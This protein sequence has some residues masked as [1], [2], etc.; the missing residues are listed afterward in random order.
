MSHIFNDVGRCSQYNMYSWLLNN[1]GAEGADLPCGQKL[2]IT[3]GKPS[4][5]AVPHPQ[6][7]PTADCVVL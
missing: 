2:S 7:Q 3:Y 6:I 1:A 4:V 5:S